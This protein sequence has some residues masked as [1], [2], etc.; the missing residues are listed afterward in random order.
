MQASKIIE[1]A[2]KFDE[3]NS[4]QRG[5]QQKCIQIFHHRCVHMHIEYDPYLY[6]STELSSG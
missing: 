1:K 2:I 4:S 5:L 6:V 3:S